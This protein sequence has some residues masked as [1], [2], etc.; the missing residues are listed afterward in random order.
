MKL[1]QQNLQTGATWYFNH[2]PQFEINKTFHNKTLQ[3]IFKFEIQP[4]NISRQPT[5]YVFYPLPNSP[6][7]KHKKKQV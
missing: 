3:N 6:P 5:W 7:K 4:K 1:Q 2:P